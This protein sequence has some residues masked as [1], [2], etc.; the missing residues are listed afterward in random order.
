MSATAP[1]PDR[2]A[3]PDPGD[4]PSRV[5]LEREPAW[6]A[7]AAAID[8]ADRGHGRIV[9]ITGEAGI[10]KSRLLREIAARDPSR[11]VVWGYCEQGETHRPLGPLHD[12]AA[13]LGGA[14]TRAL[15]RDRSPWSLHD[16]LVA[17]LAGARPA[18]VV[19][20]EDVHWAD[21]GTLEWLRLATSRTAPRPF[22]TFVTCRDPDPGLALLRGVF[23][24][25]SPWR[26]E[27][28]IV[29]GPLSPDT[30][31]GVA[32]AR[33]QDP[34]ALYRD[35]A[36]NP[37]LVFALTE[38]SASGLAGRTLAAIVRRRLET[39]RPAARRVVEAA[40]VLR[41]RAASHL[42]TGAPG[43]DAAG[44]ADAIASGL[45]VER[46]GHVRFAH[47]LVR[48]LV[49][50]SLDDE[51]ARP[52][53]RWAAAGAESEGAAARL[54]HALRLGDTAAIAELADRAARDAFAS[55]A[56]LEAAELLRIGLERGAPTD[57]RRAEWLD[58]RALALSMTPR[59][60]DAVE[61]CRAAW[62]IWLT[63]DD[64]RGR[65]ASVCT[66]LRITAAAIAGLPQFG[67]EA[68]RGV[69]DAL[70][71][72]FPP[73]ERA[74]LHAAA[75]R[76]AFNAGDRAGCERHLDLARL[77][78]ASTPVVQSLHARS[79]VLW[80]TSSYLQRSVA[81]AE[82]EL[83]ER[84]LETDLPVDSVG[85]VSQLAELSDEPMRIDRM[86][87][88]IRLGLQRCEQYDLRSQV[89]S[90]R[91]H[92]L[93]LALARGR[94]EEV[95][96]RSDALLLRTAEHWYPELR[97]AYCSA[98]ARARAGHAHVFDELA[99]AEAIV[100]RIA[101]P[102]ARA[103]V[104]LARAECEWLAGDADAATRSLHGAARLV[105]EAPADATV[106]RRILFWHLL[107]DVETSLP[108]AA[109][110]PV[111]AAAA[112]GDWA[113][114]AA[115]FEGMG[116]P[117]PQ[118]MCLVRGDGESRA[119]GV[120]VLARIGAAGA[121]RRVVEAWRRAG[122]RRA[123]RGPRPSTLAHPQRLTRREDAMLPYFASTL[124]IDEVAA[125]VGRSPRTVEHQFA[126]IR[127]KVG[128]TRREFAR[129]LA[130]GLRSVEPAAR[131][132]D[133]PEG[134]GRN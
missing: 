80:I 24:D 73:G 48:H 107:L 1:P 124:S 115:H 38:W 3:P 77:S 105:A 64:P 32:R 134:S 40:A 88:F 25:A 133:D 96:A 102:R 50:D 131:L 132:P 34:D 128:A 117:Y 109:G 103:L 53:H 29:L 110:H 62:A 39:L 86:E 43:A 125:L 26:D 79:L 97:R 9:W 36:G 11:T 58:R 123:P 46:D 4:A 82:T 68:L 63:L 106:V 94:L 83:L 19:V 84:A 99:R 81:P 116:L 22:A 57:A 93:S 78:Y 47:E 30:V 14:L 18:I 75:A 51:R 21:Q 89:L 17:D 52:L 56:Y 15:D 100:E 44:L 104:M 5:L 111:L 65:A 55:R 108:L 28:R 120:A 112:A 118:G 130:A 121:L 85:I 98:L 126:S 66:A 101:T 45:L 90:F 76:A 42:L 41:D 33:R 91:A 60:A 8:D 70:D 127:R 27:D 72:D 119:R 6:R 92:E 13:Q 23:G 129:E 2:P 74:L 61:C 54:H 35:T 16:A 95:I 12:L 114:A 7:V 37:L 49:G 113:C 87:R 67:L 10:G 59:Q 69:I 31:A 71:D 122:D 20:I